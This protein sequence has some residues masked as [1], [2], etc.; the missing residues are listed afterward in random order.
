MTAI[1]SSQPAFSRKRRASPFSYA[2]GA[3]GW[4][5]GEN[6]A[7]DSI[8]ANHGALRKGATFSSGNVGQAF[9]LDGSS[10]FIEIPDASALRPVS[11][12]LEAWVAFD[13]AA[14]P[15]V[16]FAKPVGTG[17]SDS[18]A[19]WLQPG[20][21]NGAVGDATGLGPIINAAFLPAGGSWHHLAY[22]FDNAG[23]Q[24][25]LYI[26]GI[27]VAAGQVPKSIGYDAQPLLLGRDTENGIPQF[28]LAGRI[29]EA[30]IYSRPL[31][32]AE[33]TVLGGSDDLELGGNFD[34][35]AI[36]I[37]DENKQVVAGSMAARAP[38]Q[39]DVAGAKWSAQSRILVH[40]PGS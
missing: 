13:T 11:L 2:Y 7:Q 33:I 14:G 16:V 25:A 37:G 5:K 22:T 30:T 3:V 40:S 36:G 1:N 31:S 15:R 20:F 18:Y 28:F 19:L 21:L 38:D 8:G 26:D 29:D 27:Q 10:G 6:N 17:T 9:S 34:P 12:T 23:K 32:A 24:Q 39:P 4:W 35:I